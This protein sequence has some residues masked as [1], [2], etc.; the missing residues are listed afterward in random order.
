MTVVQLHETCSICRQG[1]SRRRLAPEYPVV[2]E[3]CNRYTARALFR[4]LPAGHR[5]H[6]VEQI[7]KACRRFV[8][9][10]LGQHGYGNYSQYRTQ[11]EEIA[12][13]ASQEL[14]TKLLIEGRQ[15]DARRR[16]SGPDLVALFVTNA[17]EPDDDGRVIWILRT[18]CSAKTLS[19]KFSDVI[20]RLK[21]NAGPPAVG[22]DS[23]AGRHWQKRDNPL[24]EIQEAIR[25]ENYISSKSPEVEALEAERQSLLSEACDGLLLHFANESGWRSDLTVMFSQLRFSAELIWL[26]GHVAG[27]GG[28]RSWPADQLVAE[29]NATAGSRPW[30][31]RPWTLERLKTARKRYKTNLK[32]L[33]RTY[34]SLDERLAFLIHLS[35]ERSGSAPAAHQTRSATD[36][37]GSTL[38]D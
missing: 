10:H 3:H 22:A 26:I 14:V 13:E 34:P 28:E 8:R 23:P 11:A 19:W 15:P 35:R 9:R 16:L 21:R 36:G 25:R 12:D 33:E 38:N 20:E 31:N 24:I 27:A 30:D 2:C 6:I 1:T 32:N 17:D 5:T 7:E 29:L 37:L 18:F 4:A